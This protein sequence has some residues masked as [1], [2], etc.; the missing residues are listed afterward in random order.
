MRESMMV[1]RTTRKF[2]HDCAIALEEAPAAE[3][4]AESESPAEGGERVGDEEGPLGLTLYVA[5]VVCKA[6]VAGDEESAARI[7]EALGTTRQAVVNEQTDG[8]VSIQRFVETLLWLATLKYKHQP[9]VPLDQKLRMLFEEHVQP[10][11]LRSD[12]SALKTATQDIVIKVRTPRERLPSQ[13]QYARPQGGRRR[14]VKRQLSE[15]RVG[16]EQGVM[17][18]YETQLELLFSRFSMFKQGRHCMGIAQW[19]TLIAS[20]KLTFVTLIDTQ[21]IFANSV[22]VHVRSSL[23]CASSCLQTPSR[24]LIRLLSSTACG[25]SPRHAA[26]AVPVHSLSPLRCCCSMR[27]EREEMSPSHCGNDA[28]AHLLLRRA[29]LPLEKGLVGFDDFKEMMVALCIYK[30]QNPFSPLHQRLD[31]FYKGCARS[32]LVDLST[33]PSEPAGSSALTHDPARRHLYPTL[34]CSRQLSLRC[35]VPLQDA[36]QGNS[37]QVS[38]EGPQKRQGQVEDWARP[39]VSI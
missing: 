5:D 35:R 18:R 19:R 14:L 6:V 26:A 20:N 2:V 7:E 3:Q 15:A 38:W 23:L 1:R 9:E 25:R 33:Q 28:D 4:E 31:D 13:S 27:G 37:L 21:I 12:N 29:Q 39:I 30:N 17:E 22:P 32:A 24:R 36:V 16:E 11:A 8:F 10:L 34:R